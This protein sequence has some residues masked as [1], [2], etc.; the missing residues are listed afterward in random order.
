MDALQKPPALGALVLTDEE[1]AEQ[2]KHKELV[3]LGP[4]ALGLVS[5]V[6]PLV[7]DPEAPGENEQ[8]PARLRGA[9]SPSDLV[10]DDDT[11][12]DDEDEDEDLTD[13]EVI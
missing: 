11:G 2:E 1:L 8:V 7:G 3:Q 4:L 9:A 5:A 13:E 10:G 6:G 12:D